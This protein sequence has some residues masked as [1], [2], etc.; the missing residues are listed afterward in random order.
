MKAFQE[1]LLELGVAN[2][3]LDLGLQTCEI[4]EMSDNI[5]RFASKNVMTKED[6]KT[7]IQ[8][9]IGG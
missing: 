4:S 1:T 9:S 8:L 2:T 6:I 5:E 7:I 3:I